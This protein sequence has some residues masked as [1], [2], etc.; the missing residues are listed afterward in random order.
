MSDLAELHNYLFP[1]ILATTDL[2]PDLVVFSEEKRDVILIELT[3][4][5]E[6]NFMKAQQRKKDKYHEVTREVEANGSNVDL[7]TLE[8]GSQGFVCP[9]GF[10]LLRDIILATHSQV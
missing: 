7:I 4:P 10:R 2:R 8:V 9:D 6:I 5:F 3:I 1:P